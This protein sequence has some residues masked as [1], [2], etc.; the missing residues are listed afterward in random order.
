MYFILLYD[1]RKGRGFG[2]FLFLFLRRKKKEQNSHFFSFL[3]ISER[4]LYTNNIY[5][6]VLISLRKNVGGGVVV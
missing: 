3:S 1:R 6:F 2:L 4:R 5:R